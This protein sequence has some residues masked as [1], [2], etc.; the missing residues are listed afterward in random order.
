MRELCGGITKML[1]E[2]QTKWG[3]NKITNGIVEGE[4]WKGRIL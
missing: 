1:D 3:K 4:V 2:W